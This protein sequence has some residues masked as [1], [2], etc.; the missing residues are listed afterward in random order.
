MFIEKINVLVGKAVEAAK[1]LATR[2]TWRLQDESSLKCMDIMA[3]NSMNVQ[4]A[5]MS[6]EVSTAMQFIT[7]LYYCCKDIDYK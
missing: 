2:K 5:A 7:S 1:V 6:E 4:E 3:K